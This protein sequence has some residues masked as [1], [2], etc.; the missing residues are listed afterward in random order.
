MYTVVKE[1]KI[2]AY[3]SATVK[4][5]TQQHKCKGKL[6]SDIMCTVS[7]NTHTQC[8]ILVITGEVS[9]AGTAFL[10]KS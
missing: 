3:F 2:S 9:A 1:G 10:F 5:V 8:N 4:M 6:V 7:N